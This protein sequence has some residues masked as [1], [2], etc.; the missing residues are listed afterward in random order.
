MVGRQGIRIR[1]W[2]HPD[3]DEVMK[4]HRIL[5]RVQW[6]QRAQYGFKVVKTLIAVT[7]TYVRTFQA[8]HLTGV[9][10]SLMNAPYDVVWIV[11]EAGGST[12]ETGRILAKSGL[13]VIHIGF[14]RHMPVTWEDRHKMEAQMRFHALRVV[15]DEKLDGIV[16]FADDSNMHSLEFFDEIQKVNWFGAVSVGFVAHSATVDQT[17][18]SSSAAVEKE[19]S[20]LKTVQGPVCNSSDRL[21]GWHTFDSLTHPGKKTRYIDERALEVPQKLEWAGFVL[22]S[23]LLWKD[24]DHDKPEWA[25][26]LDSLGNVESPLCLLKDHSLVEP[27]G[28][29]GRKVLLWWFRVEARS[30]SKFPTGWT[31]NHPLEI[32]VPAKWTPWPDAPPEVSANENEI[33]T[34][35]HVQI[36][37]NMRTQSSQLKRSLRGKRKHGARAADM[38]ESKMNSEEK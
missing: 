25:N 29:C 21:V 23:R 9:M 1:P 36:R 22:N 28:S 3:P 7:P 5:E 19:Y 34:Q 2:P 31:I 13:R 37:T 15:R 38:H 8:L 14:D 32:T 24:G 18:S 20:E 10:H 30:D 16:L 26:D 35:E 4:A 17:P 27:L 33:N 11:I 6:E 12:N